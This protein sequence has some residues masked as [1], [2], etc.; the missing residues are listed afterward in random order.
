MADETEQLTR[1]FEQFS[2]DELISLLRNRDTKEW[3]P[4]VFD[5]VASVLITRGVSATVVAMGPEGRAPTVTVA[6][7]P[8][9]ARADASPMEI[10]T[11][12]H[13]TF[14]RGLF[15]R[16]PLAAWTDSRSDLRAAIADAL[17][18]R[19]VQFA[20]FNWS[21]GNSMHARRDAGFA[22]VA[23]LLELFARFPKA[24][25][26][27]VAHSHG[28]NIAMYALRT[29]TIRSRIQSVTC[30]STPF[31]HVVP[32][33]YGAQMGAAFQLAAGIGVV[34][35]G[36]LILFLLIHAWFPTAQATTAAGLGWF[37]SHLN[38]T[39]WA[40]LAKA[41]AIGLVAA[42]SALFRPLLR[43]WR[44]WAKTVA[45]ETRLPTALDL[46]LLIVRSSGDEASSLL[47]S[48]QLASAALTWLVRRLLRYAPQPQRKTNRGAN[49]L[50]QVILGVVT[51]PIMIIAALPM[52]L[53]FGLDASL[54]GIT[55]TISAEPTPPGRWSILHLTAN[56]PMATRDLL[57]HATYADPRATVEVASWIATHAACAS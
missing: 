6:T 24:H 38:P 11:L 7:L 44:R 36:L 48:A 19:K 21:G 51:F 32:R 35:F 54:A 23:F 2:T 43:R 15:L 34:S 30:L 9:P 47:G 42:S 22:L 57:S 56:G 10:V 17:R 4:E 50:A 25:H 40:Q 37:S 49:A 5:I 27:I 8:S 1:Q 20:I 46:P 16:R 33:R 55:L 53:T 52:L 29:D 26:H 39:T 28:G 45:R 12:V 13:G 31:L 3:R 41:I 18:P 14:A